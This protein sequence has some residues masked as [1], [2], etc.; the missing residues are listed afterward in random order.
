MDLHIIVHKRQYL[1]NVTDIMFPQALSPNQR[2]Y[3]CD[4]Q[5]PGYSLPFFLLNLH[6]LLDS[7]QIMD[8]HTIII[9]GDL[10][11]LVCRC[12][13]KSESNMSLLN[14]NHTE[15]KQP[16]L[17]LWQMSLLFF[18]ICALFLNRNQGAIQQPSTMLCTTIG[19]VTKQQ[20]KVTKSLWR[21]TFHEI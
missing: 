8:Q 5:H 13:S 4:V 12:I 21:I 16:L 7:L 19:K 9:C 2:D 14:I 15:L 10:V 6:S 18:Y 20:Q 1:Q 17:C 3:C 11:I